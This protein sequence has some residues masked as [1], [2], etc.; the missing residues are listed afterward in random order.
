MSFQEIS[1]SSVIWI[2]VIIGI[3]IVTSITVYYLNV[4]YKHALEVG[5][6]KATLRGVIKS[7]ISFSIVPSIAIVAGLASL[8]IVIGL[9]YAWF[10]LSV[11]GSV[12]YEILAAQ[13]AM[14]AI[15]VNVATANAYAFG[16]MAWSMC[17]AI[18]TTLIFNIWLTKKIHLGTLSTS[19]GDKKWGALFQT[20]FMTA[21]LCA[22]IVPML[23]GG[24]VS[25]LT[26]ASSA[27]IALIITLLAKKTKANWLNSFTLAFSLLGAMALS[28][29]Y[30]NILG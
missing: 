17:I 6:T 14:T 4:C 8:A 5:I 19:S 24:V 18:T 23:A 11:L 28:V 10:R 25:L 9:P 3:I 27:A 13:M 1:G 21:L 12:A 15:G 7:S 2:C 16:L 22:L 29:V 30:T 20:I 26:Y